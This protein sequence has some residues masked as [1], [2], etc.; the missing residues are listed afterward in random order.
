LRHRQGVPEDIAIQSLDYAA[1]NRHLSLGA[2]G[3]ET[4]LHT[5]EN[6][7]TEIV[8]LLLEAGEPPSMDALNMAVRNG[9]TQ[10]AQLLLNWGLSS[11][12]VDPLAAYKASVN[13]HTETLQLLRD[14]M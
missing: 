14:R 2:R 6:G 3:Q 11:A 9:R 5:S 7:S 10:T 8:R 4:L 13:G 1:T 12:D